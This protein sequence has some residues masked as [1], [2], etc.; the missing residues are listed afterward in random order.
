MDCIH[1]CNYVN[2][3]NKN[4]SFCIHTLMQFSH[5]SELLT[6]HIKNLAMYNVDGLLL[7]KTSVTTS[8]LV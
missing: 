4:N 8:R 7:Q 5:D 1:I 2:H 3:N 6:Q